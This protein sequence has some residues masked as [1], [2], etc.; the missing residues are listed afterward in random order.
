VILALQEITEGIG[1]GEDDSA[2]QDVDEAAGL[3]S[4]LVETEGLSQAD[5]PLLL[6]DDDGPHSRAAARRLLSYLL[7]DEDTAAVAGPV[8]ADPPEDGQLAVETAIVGAVVLGA[9]TTW[10]RTKIDFT[11]KREAR[12]T[13]EFHLSKPSSDPATIRKIVTIILELLNGPPQA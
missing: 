2:P 4:A 3:L 1:P 8:V 9:L 13:F 7:Q 5:V 6:V 10:L 12:V 11:I